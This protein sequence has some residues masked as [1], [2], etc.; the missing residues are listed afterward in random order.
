MCSAKSIPNPLFFKENKKRRVNC[1]Q[2]PDQIKTAS[3]TTVEHE[4][5]SA[6][7]YSQAGCQLLHKLSSYY[8][9]WVHIFFYCSLFFFCHAIFLWQE[10]TCSAWLHLHLH[11]W[12]QPLNVKAWSP[13]REIMSFIFFNSNVRSQWKYVESFFTWAL[14]FISKC[15]ACADPSVCEPQRACGDKRQTI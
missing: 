7:L 12:R 2:R 14:Y 1:S 15:V 11:S 5:C 6:A 8:R 13:H 10:F 9:K 3:Q 4:L